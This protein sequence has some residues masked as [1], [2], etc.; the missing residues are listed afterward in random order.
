MNI[1]T[2]GTFDGLHPGHL[3]LLRETRRLAGPGGHVWVG[4]N[5]DSFVERY[6]GRPPVHNLLTRLETLAALRD[7]DQVFINVGDEDSGV[8]IET[9]NPDMLSIGSDWLDPGRDQTRY[10]TQLGVTADWMDRRNLS[11]AYIPRT[12]GFSSSALREVV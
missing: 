7:V 5:R 4:V 1:L 6:K 12:R 11:V 9:V 8:L 10:L 3:E 2:I